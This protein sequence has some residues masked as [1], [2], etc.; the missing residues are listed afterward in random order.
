MY[1]SITG[2]LI[3]AIRITDLEKKKIVID[4]LVD[5]IKNDNSVAD[6]FW[7][8]YKQ[9]NNYVASFIWANVPELFRES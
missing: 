6:F 1:K 2:P 4:F 3:Q 5:L 7:E 8:E 9:L